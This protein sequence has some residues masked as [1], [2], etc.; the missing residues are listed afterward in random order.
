[1]VSM[2]EVAKKAGVSVATVSNVLNNRKPISDYVKKRVEVAVRQMDYKINRL[3]SGLKSIKTYVI[4]LVLPRI[5]AVYFP[6]VFQLKCK[7]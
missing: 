2:R 3:A 4:G 1:M 7:I 5:A 6:N